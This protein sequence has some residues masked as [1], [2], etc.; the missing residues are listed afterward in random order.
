MPGMFDQAKAMLRAKK[1]QDEL[2]KTEIEAAGNGVKVVFTGDLKLAQIEVD[3]AFLSPDRKAELERNL[4]DTIT[5]GMQQAQQVAAEKTREVM[6]ELG[7][8]IPGL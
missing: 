5:Q 7:V 3:E 1:A 6:K 2:K 4:K 8:N